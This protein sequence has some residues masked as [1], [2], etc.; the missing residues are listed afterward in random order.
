MNK[1]LQSIKNA[2]KSPEIKKKLLFTAF[3]FAVFRIF[4]YTPLP[5]VDLVRLKDLFSKSEFLGLLDIFSGGTLVNFS[6]MAIGLNPYIN[7]SIILQLLTIVFP[8]LEELS[9][10][11]EYGREKINQYT[12]FLTVPL[13]AVQSLGMYALLHNQGIITT[14]SPFMLISLILSMTAGTMLLMWLG[15]LISEFGIGNGISVL[16][17]AGIVGRLPLSI[18]R[19]IAVVNQELLLNVLVIVVISFIVIAAIV[20]INEAVRQVPVHYAKRVRGNKIYGGSSTYLPLRLNQAGVIPI[21]FAVSLVLLPSMFGQFAEQLPNKFIA[22]FSKILVNIFQTDGIVYNSAYFLLVIGFTYFY[23]AITFNPQK[24]AA[25]IQKYGG[26]IPGIRP[27]SSTASYLNYILTRITLAGAIFLGTIAI[28]PSL[29]KH[30]TGISALTVGGT[31]V[32][33]VVSVVL[34]TVKQIEAQLVMRNYEGFL[35]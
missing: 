22:G 20:F 2:F 29:M 9:K 34:E 7:A 28:F 11:G 6:V 16:I 17:F 26:F 3:I 18:G 10:E 12:R 21:I 5:G 24:I 1:Y 25:E 23:T 31:S 30:I 27:G 15:E 19:T 8:K 13:A 35:K 4:A 33:I 32:L 14:L